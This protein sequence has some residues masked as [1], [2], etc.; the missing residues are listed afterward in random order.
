MWC[1]RQNLLLLDPSSIFSKFLVIFYAVK[2]NFKYILILNLS[3]F[4]I[5]LISIYRVQTRHK[6]ILFYLTSLSCT[7]NFRFIVILICKPLFLTLLC[8]CCTVYGDFQATFAV[9][10]GSYHK[11]GMKMSRDSNHHSYIVFQNR[12]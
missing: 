4:P 6:I 10:Q 11:K 1:V 7:F 12:T 2:T 5:H 8:T 3:Y 9:K